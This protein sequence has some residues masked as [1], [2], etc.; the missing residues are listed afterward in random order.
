MYNLIGVIKVLITVLSTVLSGVFVFI[1]GQLFIEYVLHPIQKY[2]ALKSKIAYLLVYYGNL[3]TNPAGRGTRDEKY[4]EASLELRKAAA[5]CGAFGEEKPKL[6]FFVPKKKDFA[7][8][9][10]CL[11]FLSNNMYQQASDIYRQ[12]DEAVNCESKIKKI[13]RISINR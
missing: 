7:E 3:Y 8:V 13:L 11:I 1:L 6:T 4:D 2:K 12:I 5:E 9:M 10:G